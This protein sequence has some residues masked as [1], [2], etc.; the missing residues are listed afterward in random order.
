M[1]ITAGT[2]GF[3]DL[4]LHQ[5]FVTEEE[6]LRYEQMSRETGRSLEQIL[7]SEAVLDED[8]LQELKSISAPKGKA[9]LDILLEEQFVSPPQ[10]SKFMQ[11]FAEPPEDIG[12]ILLKNLLI[13]D[14]QYAQGLAIHRSLEFVDLQ[15]FEPDHK[16][17]DIINPSLMKKFRFV[18]LELTNRSFTIAFADPQE[19]ARLDN[20]KNLLYLDLK[21]GIVIQPKICTYR[22]LNLFFEKLEGLS[23]DDSTT[24]FETS[25]DRLLSTAP[26]DSENWA[27]ELAHHEEPL[28]LADAGIE[29]DVRTYDLTQIAADVDLEYE[30]LMVEKKSDVVLDSKVDDG[31]A[32]VTKFVN[33]I[34]L[35]AVE[36][37][38]S[39]IHFEATDRHLRV[40]YR[41]DGVLLDLLNMSG[42]LINPVVSRIKVMSELDIAKKMVPQDGRFRARV[43]TRNVDFRVSTLPSIYG[44]TSVIRI[45]DKGVSKLS[46][47]EVGLFDMDLLK[48]RR[49]IVK[50]Y[51]M[52]LVTGPTGSGKTTSL[53]AMLNA[54]KSPEV[55]IITIEDPVEYELGGI[56]QVPV[57]EKMGLTFARGLRSIVRQDPDKVLVGEIRDNET[58]EIAINAALTG[59]LV[60][61]SI[62]ANNVIDAVGRLM[63]MGIDPYEFV[64]SFNLILAQRLVRTICPMCKIV[65]RDG[66]NE[67]AELTHDWQK[68]KDRTFYKGKGCRSCKF[69]GY[70]GRTGIFE[71][72]EMSDDVKDMILNKVSPIKVKG[73]AQA[74]GMI[75]LRE[76][77]WRKVL[78]GITTLQELNRVT[79][80]EDRK[81]SKD[82][83]E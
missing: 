66:L 18:P 50:P 12:E 72:L 58:A 41:V 42:K 69:T 17:L 75:S 11:N 60:L 78:V 54:V 8:E 76:S 36:D 32:P 13:T 47:M 22:A 73:R 81:E 9:F 64:S 49:N 33:A 68:Y 45:L 20:L 30:G 23:S 40:R 16:V 10:I 37:R 26:L 79:F 6:L 4:L 25:S 28:S 80:E 15:G 52:I 31:G 14:D 21:T 57:N 74:E 43:G 7:I 1:N 70:A 2:E 67:V 5:G 46:L 24:P 27:R 38:A 51:G 77:G 65:D 29:E 61:S 53:Y 59:H 71:T 55:K 56:V 63:N 34:L 62:H 44:E 82:S 39:D 19:L 35:K 83:E 48:V 3:R